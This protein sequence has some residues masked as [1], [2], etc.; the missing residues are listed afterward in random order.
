MG[1][2]W[3]APSPETEQRKNGATAP[4]PADEETPAPGPIQFYGN[5]QVYSESGVDLTMLRENLNRTATQRLARNRRGLELVRE[6]DKSRFPKLGTEQ[7]PASNVMI[8]DEKLLRLLVEKGVEFVLIGGLAMRAQGS[9]HITEDADICY[10]RTKENILRLADAMA[11]YHPYM[12]GAPLGLP[13]HFDALTIQAGLNFTLNSD[14]GEVDFL[15]E[16][17]GIGNFEKVLAQSEEQLLYGLPV[18]VLSLDGLLL[19]KKAAARRKDHGHILELEELKKMR[20]EG[21]RS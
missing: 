6:L 9:V 21:A 4:A 13:F 12:R 8:E 10:A 3:K 20:D 11:S 15:G 17:S 5:Y 7:I 14:L 18:R 1:A 19:A 2:T 16:V